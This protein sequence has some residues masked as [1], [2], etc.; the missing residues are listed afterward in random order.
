MIRAMIQAESPQKPLS[1]SKIVEALEKK[2]VE[3]ARRTVAKY[4]EA[5]GIEAAS[6][7]KARAAL[8]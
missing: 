2:G 3:I 7:R 5:E 1:D 6:V 4:R 8:R